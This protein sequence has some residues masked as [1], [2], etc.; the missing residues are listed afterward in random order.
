M[1]EEQV[2]R[3]RAQKDLYFK[4]NLQSPLTPAQRSAFT[5]LEYYPYNPDLDLT[6]TVEPFIADDVAQIFTTKDMI[7]NYR[8]YGRF[9]FATAEGS[10]SLTI[11]ETPHGF[12]I[13]FVDALAGKETYPAGRY[14]DAQQVEET[15]F[16]VDFNQA[17]NPY[18]AYNDYY[19]CPI[20][21]A[22]NRLS[23][24]IPAGEKLP[25]GGWL[26]SVEA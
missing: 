9:A 16:H 1:S 14:I 23:V 20:T 2:T 17:Y 6:V 10:A 19:D 7:R 4:R 24:G 22:E 13:P 26:H 25:R 11:Y 5:A 3:L 15:T 18:C 8:R 12:F 21:P